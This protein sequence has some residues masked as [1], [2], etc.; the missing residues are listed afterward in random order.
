MN[1][2]LEAQARELGKKSD[3]KRLRREGLIPAVVYGEGK[4]SIPVTVSQQEFMKVYRQGIGQMAFFD[5]TVDG[6][7][8][9]T[10]VKEKQFH[11][12]SRELLHIDFQELHAGKEITLEI[13]LKYQGEAVGTQKGGTLDI[14][15]RSLHCHSLPRNIKED[16]V[17]DIT[18]LE[19]G[20]SI[21][22]KDLD[23]GEMHTKLSPDL[24]VVSVH[25]PRGAKEEAE[26]E[27][28]DEKTE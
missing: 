28:G 11:P 27:A 25:L 3:R 15:V 14:A 13:P 24:A 12:L 20:E 26:E 8:Y 9:R 10:I 23:L 17:V 19:L 18:N 2:K 16:I 22:V 21:H 1:L 7:T 5:V 6:A 4:P